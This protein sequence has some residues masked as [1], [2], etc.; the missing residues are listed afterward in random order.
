[1]MK[2]WKKL[3]I[4]MVIFMIFLAAFIY[5]NSSMNKTGN[6]S[7]NLTDIASSD[8]IKL[9]DIEQDDISKIVLKREEDE[10]V[11]ILEERDVETYET[12]DDGT[13]K[14]VTEKK[15]VWVNQSFDVD[16]DLVE[17]MVSTAAT[18]MTDR[19]INEN[20]ADPTI[21]GLDNSY[22]TTFVSKDGKEVS[23]E[24]GDLTPLQNSYYI[25]KP[26]NP[27]VYTIDSYQGEALRYGKL[28]LMNK[29][30]YGTEAVSDEDVKS[31][32]FNRDGETVFSA[33]RKGSSADWI[34]T[35]PIPQ[36]DAN[37][38]EL[39]KFLDWVSTF[40][41]K[42]YV[43]EDPSDLSLYGL[44][45]PKYVFDYTL[46]GKT[47]R[48]LLGN[49]NESEYYGMMEGNNTVFTVDAYYLDFVDLSLK[50]LVTLTAYNPPIYDVEKLVIE[51]DGKRD[52]LLIDASREEGSTPEFYFNGNKIE[53]GEQENRFRKYYQT[54]AGITADRIDLDSVPSGKAA[55]SLTYTMKKADPDKTVKVDFIP[56][57]DGYGYFIMVNDN[58]TGLVISERKLFDDPDTGIRQACKNLTESLS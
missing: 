12:N 23:I 37:T 39:S 50:D 30:L 24:I 36:R 41:V 11:L 22:V 38:D 57:N 52:V 55:V 10:V 51:A 6:E 43:K 46:N 44:D 5:L 58:Y 21:Y 34:I 28:D 20:P 48:M 2:N 45:S 14:K 29:N 54:A 35:G 25:R 47:Y 27:E 4:L 53:S 42:E 26:G 49:K 3:I 15:K 8:E 1:M 33:E 40:R 16:N 17:Y 7:E 32:T 56:A 18:V 13:T 19:L 31:L 9:V